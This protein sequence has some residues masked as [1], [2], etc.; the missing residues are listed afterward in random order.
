MNLRIRPTWRKDL[1]SYP[2]HGA[3]G[4]SS[5]QS[6]S[7]YKLVLRVLQLRYGGNSSSPSRPLAKSLCWT[8]LGKISVFLALCCCCINCFRVVHAR[9][10]PGR[11]KSDSRYTSRSQTLT[12]FQTLATKR[13]RNSNATGEQLSEESRSNESPSEN[14]A[15]VPLRSLLIRSIIIPLANETFLAFLDICIFALMPLFYSTPHYLGGLGFTPQTIGLW[16][17]LFGII[18]GL[19]QALFFAKIVDRLGPKRTFY[20]GIS[21]FI[22]IMVMFPV[23][24]WLVFSGGADYMVSIAL[25]CQLLLI[26]AWDLSLGEA[27]VI[28]RVSIV[29]IML[30]YNQRVYIC[31]LPRPHLRKMSWARSMVWVK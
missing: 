5:G 4:A 20:T 24:S 14:M 23:M 11:G 8:I 7:E 19:F 25:L 6:F 1:L 18:D 2:S 10:S 29:G 30:T 17:A 26:V 13:K 9:I 27:S 3:L 21:C 15:N 16:M 22:P 31:L 12:L 28:A